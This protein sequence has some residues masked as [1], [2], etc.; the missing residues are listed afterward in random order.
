[1][2]KVLS[3]YVFQDSKFVFIWNLAAN[4]HKFVHDRMSINMSVRASNQTQ[5]HTKINRFICILHIK[6]G[7][8]HL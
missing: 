4:L 8:M 1:M 7:A 3:K 5:V 6:H 2:K